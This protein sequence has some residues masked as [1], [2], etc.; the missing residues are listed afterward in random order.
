MKFSETAESD[1]ESFRDAPTDRKAATQ[2][3]L[4]RYAKNKAGRLA[5]RMLPKMHQE[6][7][8]GAVGANQG[9]TGLTPPT[10]VHYLLTVMVPKLGNQL[11]MR[12]LRELRTLCTA[13][14]HLTMHRPAQAADLLTQR[15]KALEK[16]TADGDWGLAQFL[17]LL[18]P[19]TSGLLDRQKEMK[20]RSRK[21]RKEGQRKRQGQGDPEGEAERR[22]D[23]TDE[24]DAFGRWAVSFRQMMRKPMSPAE[25]FGGPLDTGHC[26]GAPRTIRADDL[27]PIDPKE[28]ATY[29]LDKG[30]WR[31][32]GSQLRGLHQ[33]LQPLQAAASMAPYCLR[34][35]L[36]RGGATW[37]FQ[38]SLSL[39]ATVARGRWSCSRTARAYIDEGY[40]TTCPCLL[41]ERTAPVSTQWARHLLKIRLRQE[42]NFG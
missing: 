31:A 20:R 34:R 1:S 10:A 38:S 35:C 41:D 25:V 23:L 4:V 37:H 18:S 9:K 3:Q 17:E 21:R 33:L 2:L 26:Q 40:G 15:V 30:A 36:R 12:S 42:A 14:D 22:D 16:A 27:L 28:V 24:E 5:S 29:L 32:L 7:A 19:E 39:D 13:I 11:N 8:Q 6:R